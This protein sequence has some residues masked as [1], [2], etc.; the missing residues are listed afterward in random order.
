MT[1][2]HDPKHPCAAVIPIETQLEYLIDKAARRG[3]D[4]ALAR[5]G[6]DEHNIH[7]VRSML[8]VLHAIKK[9]TLNAITK[10]IMVAIIASVIAVTG[11]YGLFEGKG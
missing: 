5:L 1:E 8:E 3:A 7:E 9:G 2:P 4:E 10:L 11:W 6:I